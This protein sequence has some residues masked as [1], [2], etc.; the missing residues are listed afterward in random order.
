MLY[1]THIYVVYL[2]IHNIV[3]IFCIIF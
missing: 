3:F 2:F 1:S